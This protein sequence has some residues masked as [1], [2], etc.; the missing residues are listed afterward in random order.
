[1]THLYIKGRLCDIVLTHEDKIEAAKSLSVNILEQII[2][3][4]RIEAA[5]NLPTEILQ[6]II[7]QKKK[8]NNK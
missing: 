7:T 2:F 3:K 5:N 6:E 4:K 8:E 1:M